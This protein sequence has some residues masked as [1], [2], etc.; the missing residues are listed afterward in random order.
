MPHGTRLDLIACGAAP[1]TLARLA[2]HEEAFLRLAR[3][4]RIVQGDGAP[5]PNALQIL[6]EEAIL[7]L[8]V[9]EA[10]DIAQERQRLGN[11]IAKAEAEVSSA[12]PPSSPIRASSS[13]P[14]PRWSRSTGRVWPR[15][16]PSASA[17]PR[18]CGASP[19]A[20]RGVSGHARLLRVDRTSQARPIHVVSSAGYADWLAAAGAGDPRLAREQP[21]SRPSPARRGLVPDADGG[22]EALHRRQRARPSPGT[23]RGPSHSCPAAFGAST[24]PTSSCRR[25]RR[26]GLGAR[27]LPLRALPPGA[28]RAPAAR[29]RRGFRPR[30][31]PGC[32]AEAT[33]QARDLV[34]TPASDLG[35]AELAQAVTELAGGF[36]ATS[37][38]I[39]GDA[40][41]AERYPADPCRRPCQRARA[42]SGRSRLGRAWAPAA[43]PWSARACA[44]TQAASTSSPRAACC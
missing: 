11:G 35:P 39:V 8:P 36:G 18:P 24:T 5:P 1:Q 26:P 37:R 28:G 38:T 19:T 6:V 13:A 40:L 12:S 17:W 16:R 10:I 14:R 20:E 31:Q 2:R 33:W 30:A 9:G 27:G 42:A 25:R 7:A 23:A 3:L 29:R 32:L 41:L 44:S 43:S 21:A 22:R 34:N 15:P 4:R